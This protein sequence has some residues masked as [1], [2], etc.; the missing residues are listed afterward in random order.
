MSGV[1]LYMISPSHF[2]GMLSLKRRISFD[3]SAIPDDHLAVVQSFQSILPSA[4]SLTR[5]QLL[6][7]TAV[8]SRTL[9][10]PGCLEK[11]ISEDPIQSGVISEVYK[12][13]CHI[14]LS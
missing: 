10:R 2:H 9:T 1:P 11:W 12:S 8:Q 13:S 7:L 14:D 6:D 4:A 3:M 5:Q